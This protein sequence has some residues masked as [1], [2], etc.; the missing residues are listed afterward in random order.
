MQGFNIRKAAQVAA[1]F[2]KAEGGS[3]NVLKLVKLVYLA[4]RKFME[5][6]DCSILHDKLVS[7][8]HGPVNSTTLNLI[9]GL[10][11]DPRHEWDAF[12][13]GRQGNVVRL[14]NPDIDTNDLDE[15]SEAELEV[16]AEIAAQFR[17]WDQFQIRDYTHDHCA[18][19]ED[20]DGSSAPI[21]Y[22]LLFAVLGKTDPGNL[23]AAV[24]EERNMI[25][26]LST[27]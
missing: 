22:K 14:T 23:A 9:N 6:Y 16:L 26:I 8:E 25:S 5:Q 19:W 7:M 4:D 21:P 13:S 1:F 20:P 10:A 15:L 17:E 27:E 18:E 2:A 12:L 11:N 3:I 24:E